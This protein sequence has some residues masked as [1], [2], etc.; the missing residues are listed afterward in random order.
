MAQ[1]VFRYLA[2]PLIFVGLWFG[3]R[4]DRFVTWLLLATILYYLV[5]GSAL[6]MEI[7]Y[8]LPMQCLLLIFAGLGILGVWERFGSSRQEQ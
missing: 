7:R 8:G 1:S 3:F 2:L 5:A 4:R 6:H